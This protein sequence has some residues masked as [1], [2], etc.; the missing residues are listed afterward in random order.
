MPIAEFKTAGKLLMLKTGVSIFLLAIVSRL[1]QCHR[2]SLANGGAVPAF[3]TKYCQRYSTSTFKVPRPYEGIPDAELVYDEISW[4]LPQAFK[5]S[6]LTLGKGSFG[7]VK[8]VCFPFH[9][10]DNRLYHQQFPDQIAGP[11]AVKQ[12]L[13]KQVRQVELEVM[14]RL[15]IYDDAPRF[16]GCM[17]DSTGEY[18]Y[19]AQTRYQLPLRKLISN[20]QGAP[21]MGQRWGIHLK[22]WIQTALINKLGYIHN[23]IKPDNT[24]VTRNG[25]TIAIIDYGL[26]QPVG[27][28]RKCMGSPIYMPP[29]KCDAGS[30]KA[31][32]TDDLYSVVISMYEM[33]APQGSLDD[34]DFYDARRQ[35]VNC[36]ANPKPP[37][38]RDHIHRVVMNRFQKVYPDLFK[39]LNFKIDS[40]EKEL[41]QMNILDLMSNVLLIE[42]LETHPNVVIRIAQEFEKHVEKAYPFDGKTI[43]LVPLDQAPE[44]CYDRKYEEKLRKQV[45]NLDWLLK[46]KDEEIYEYKRLREST[47]KHTFGVI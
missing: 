22:L 24:M 13:I 9:T 41:Y 4:N 20:F 23:D 26:A 15:T 39:S 40:P 28:H 2:R 35:K 42:N 37:G 44:G 27:D 31:T 34:L 19:I 17:V 14:Y 36:Y 12:V 43:R 6:G 10:L 30:K 38:C 16:Y 21:N 11:I 33:E 32:L 45:A 46:T 25:W 7:T 18:L 3:L 1:G 5:E 47:H 29:M 8:E